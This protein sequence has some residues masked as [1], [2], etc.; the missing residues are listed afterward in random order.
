M[1]K[2]MVG[3]Y[4][5]SKYNILRSASEAAYKGLDKSGYQMNT[6]LISPQKHMLWVLIRSAQHMFSW[7]NKKNL[8]TFGWKKHLIK[9]CKHN[10]IRVDI[11]AVANDFI[12]GQ[13]MG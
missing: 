7:R 3:T 5:N 11:S 13:Q 2:G 9:S 12:I 1:R 10:L 8:N 4:V 6:F